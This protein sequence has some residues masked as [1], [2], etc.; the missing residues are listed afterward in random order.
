MKCQCH[1]PGKCN[2]LAMEPDGLCEPCRGKMG[3]ELSRITQRDQPL[4]RLSKRERKLGHT[5][6]NLRNT[7]I[8]SLA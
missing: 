6:V 7:A 8:P 2:G 3:E 4:A 1:R 5:E